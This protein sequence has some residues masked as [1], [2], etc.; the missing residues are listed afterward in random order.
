LNPGF[1]IFCNAVTS[2]WPPDPS[3]FAHAIAA[4]FGALVALE[5]GSEHILR[6]RPAAVDDGVLP[7]DFR[8]SRPAELHCGAGFGLRLRGRFVFGFTTFVII[9]LAAIIF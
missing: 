5:A 6:A 8:R 2:F 7:L 9:L 4:A 1:C 3:L